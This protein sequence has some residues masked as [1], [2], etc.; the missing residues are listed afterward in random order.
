MTV[1]WVSEYGF[2]FVPNRPDCGVVITSLTCQYAPSGGAAATGAGVTS[3]A[4]SASPRPRNIPLR[5]T[6][7]L[8]HEYE[9]MT[10]HTP[11]PP[12]WLPATPGQPCGTA[13]AY[14]EA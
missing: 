5:D 8:L 11:G 9:V 2:A 7:A 3:A 13:Q 14:K 4:P 6:A 10:I 1:R 12:A